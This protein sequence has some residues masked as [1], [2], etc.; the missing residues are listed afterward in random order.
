VAIIPARNEAESISSTLA[1]IRKQTYPV[2][3]VIVVANNCSDNTAAIAAK[4]GAEVII[5]TKNDH[6]KSGALNNALE[7]VIPDLCDDDCVLIMDAD[8]N[9]S[10]DLV[11]Q[12][13][14]T[15]NDNPRAGAVGSIF[16]GRPSD[17]LLGR[18]QLMEYW[19]YKRQ[20]H[21]NGNRAF[22]L[23]GTAS[24]FLVGTL[25]AVKNARNNGQIPYGG[26]SYYDIIGRTE[27]N[28]IT[29]AILKLGYDCPMAEVFSVT[30]VMEKVGKL[31]DQ[32]ERWYGG[33]LVNLRAYGTSLP[34]Y[35]KWVY[36][37][38]QFG[39][40]I[41]LL[42]FFLFMALLISSPFT[43][44]GI[45]VTWLWLLPI[46]ILAVE[47]TSTVWALGWKARI[48]AVSVLPEQIYSIFLLLV[49]GLAL[50]NF[51]TGRRGQWKST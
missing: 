12:C 48:L 30:D 27:D 45:T 20:I 18:L 41:S 34:W 2:D 25:H 44:G 7:R 22:V 26:G 3:R 23:S 42:A 36:W 6:M 4:N 49:Y 40:F 5:M 50:K 24:L 32:R 17:S 9:L 19:R 1:S 14:I 29:L 13:L 46:A 43:R 47:R 10:P 35:M 11:E 21:R 39:L 37:K 8:T 28:E 33:A 31:K 16:T 51:V 15:L 38:Q